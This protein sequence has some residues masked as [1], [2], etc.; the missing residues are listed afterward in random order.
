[1]ASVGS[2]VGGAFALFRDRPGAVALWALTYIVGTIIISF[3]FAGSMMM[4]MGSM[5]P[6]TMSNPAS[7][8]S[9]M[10]GSLMLF[11]LALF[12]L[13]VILMNAVFR[14]ILRPEERSVGSIRIGMDEVRMFGL[15]VVFFIAMFVLFLIVGF[16]FGMLGA[17]LGF[18]A[19][20]N[21]AGPVEIILGLAFVAASVWFYV[22]L[23]LL[24]PLSFYRRSFIELD[25][26]WRMTGGRFWTLFASYLLVWVI[27]IVLFLAIFF[28]TIGPDML[29]AMA[30]GGDPEALAQQA[31]MT[32]GFSGVRMILFFVLYLIL[33]VVSIVL[34]PAI[35]AS[36]TKQILI[37]EGDALVD[38]EQTAAV[39]E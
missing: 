12:F 39:F 32:G 15:F 7:A 19:G 35:I 23:S 18:A 3:V 33:A 6:A 36:A 11:Y 22:R 4:S 38:V 26:A 29:A 28:M 14:S 16:I 13:M 37:E 34:G 27:T 31:A 5:D 24:F 21:G 2:I 20:G 1:M 25:S 30:G 8:I 10:F 9:G 17:A